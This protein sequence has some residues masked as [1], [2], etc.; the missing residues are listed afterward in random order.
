MEY[1]ILLPLLKPSKIRSLAVILNV[2]GNLLMVLMLVMVII[3]HFYSHWLI[4][5]NLKTQA[6]NRL[7]IIINQLAQYL[8]VV[9]I[10]ILGTHQT[11]IIVVML[12]SAKLIKMMSITLLINPN[13]L[14]SLQ[15]VIRLALAQYNMKSM[16]WHSNETK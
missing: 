11:S 9:M 6:N 1:S 5:T 8:V 16:Q 3:V 4:C 10:F 13:L 15:E 7:S 12:I 2:N 14:K